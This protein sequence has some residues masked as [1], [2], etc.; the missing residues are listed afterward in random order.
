[1]RLCW[2]VSGSI[3]ALRVVVLRLNVLRKITSRHINRLPPSHHALNYFI[4]IDLRD[5]APFLRLRVGG[6]QAERVFPA[7]RFH[8]IGDGAG[9]ISHGPRA[10][11]V[12]V[13][14]LRYSHPFANVILL[15]V[16]IS[17]TPLRRLAVS[18]TSGNPS[19]DD[20]LLS[21][22]AGKPFRIGIEIIRLPDFARFSLRSIS[23]LNLAIDV[24][25]ACTFPIPFHCGGGRPPVP[26]R[27]IQK[28]LEMG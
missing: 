9:T 10:Q 1:M 21:Q 16:S 28:P 24:A 6:F 3:H 2:I 27:L 19:Q 4:A 12:L 20:I 11:P 22:R 14:P 13:P 18:I 26:F 15:H 5:Q 23:S 17:R 8:E 25:E 7:E